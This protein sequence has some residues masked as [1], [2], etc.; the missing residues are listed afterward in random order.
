MS[1]KTPLRPKLWTNRSIEE[2]IEIYSDWA[3][4]YDSDI[5]KRGYFTPLRIA[6]A[7]RP[8]R[9]TLQGPVLDFG[10]GTGVSGSALAAVGF[11]PLH[12]TDITEEMLKQAEV[13]GIYEKLWKSEPGQ[14]PAKPGEYSLIVAAGVISIGA[15][16]PET[17]SLCIDALSPDGLMALSF[18]D[19]TLEDGS[20]DAVLMDEVASGRVEFLFR[21]HGPHLNDLDMGSDIIVLRRK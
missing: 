3:S 9:D 6:E 12:G 11:A 17:L 5:T 15:A 13:K 2:T 21:E 14:S 16:P 1:D 19:P 7:L 10:C 20:Y 4:S 18:N 8:Y